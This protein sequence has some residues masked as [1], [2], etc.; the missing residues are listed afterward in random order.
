MKIN[1]VNFND[2]KNIFDYNG[3]VIPRL[4]EII[5]TFAPKKVYCVLEVNHYFIGSKHAISK[6]LDAIAVKVER[7]I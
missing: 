6:I 1:V 7:Q 2:N 4:G 3:N 5:T